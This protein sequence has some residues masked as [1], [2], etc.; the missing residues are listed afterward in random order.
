MAEYSKTAVINAPA[1][2]VWEVIRDFNG[3]GK[4]SPVVADSV[5]ETENH[6]PGGLRTITMKDGSKALD[7][8]DVLDDENMVITYSILEAEPPFPFKG[9]QA[10]MRLKPLGESSCE[11]TWSCFFLPRGDS[12][13]PA[14]EIIS[15]VYSAGI[16]GLQKLLARG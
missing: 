10:T 7:R 6:G 1:A 15:N 13:A 3:T 9:Y 2:A 5:W 14:L 12:E 4:F 8:L 16:E 11:L